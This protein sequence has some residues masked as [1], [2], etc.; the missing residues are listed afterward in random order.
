MFI[1]VEFIKVNGSLCLCP[2][3]FIESSGEN[4]KMGL[5]RKSSYI[6][7]MRVRK[8]RFVV[9]P[10]VAIEKLDPGCQLNH[11]FATRTSKLGSSVHCVGASGA[12]S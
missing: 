5:P 11:G 4:C 9:I 3:E 1:V 7:G 12:S 10:N 8:S 2:V 6:D